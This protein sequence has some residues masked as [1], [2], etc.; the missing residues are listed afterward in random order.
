MPL[1]IKV[2]STGEIKDVYR[3]YTDSNE[4]FVDLNDCLTGKHYKPGLD[5]SWYDQEKEEMRAA[6]EE[7]HDAVPRQT[8]D[9]DW[10][11]DELRD[12]MEKAKLLIRIK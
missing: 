1:Q 5:C 10:W 2:N 8:D 7:L 4:V 9:A 3:Y 6:L 11:S 12:A